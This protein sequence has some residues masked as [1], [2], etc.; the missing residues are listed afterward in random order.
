MKNR[1]ARTAAGIAAVAM[2]MMLP[3]RLMAGM[4]TYIIDKEHTSITFKIR[5]FFSK[6]PGQFNSFE[7]MLQ[8]D[9]DDQTKGSVTVTIDAASIDTNEPARD[10]HL[11]SDAFFDVESHPKLTFVSRSI[12]SAGQDKLAIDGDLTIRGIT[13]Q[14]TL[15]V[16]ALGFG[17]IYSVKRAAFEA[18][19]T[20]NRQ[21]FNVSWNDVIEGGGAILGDEVQI[22]INL[23]AKKQKEKPA[24]D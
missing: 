24:G 23:E 12:R 22:V 8:L 20:I 4:E 10:R 1:A 9:P 13:K 19:T 14:V 18:R 21:D 2:A 15:D 7:G 3:S 16:D 6:V 11:R 5:H 17:E